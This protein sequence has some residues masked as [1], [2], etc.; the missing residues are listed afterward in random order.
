MKNSLEM[1]SR[2]L[3]LIYFSSATNGS[4]AIWRER[5]IATV[6]LR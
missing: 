5:L 4:N 2:L 1:N 6:S 3:K